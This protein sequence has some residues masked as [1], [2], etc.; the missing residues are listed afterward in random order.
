[1]K[2]MTHKEQIESHVWHRE[3]TFAQ[4]WFRHGNHMLYIPATS[5]GNPSLGDPVRNRASR[6]PVECHK[7]IY[8]FKLLLF[9][10]H[11]LKFAK[12]KKIALLNS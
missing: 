12:K 9:L 10:Q 1:M 2:Y 8:P 3:C 4:L 7:N 5:P 11:I 6:K